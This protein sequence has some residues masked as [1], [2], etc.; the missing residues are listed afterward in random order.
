MRELGEV[1]A[2]AIRIGWGARNPAFRRLFTM[3]YLPEGTPEQ[4][5][6]FEELQ[7]T[8]ASPATAARIWAARMD[9]DVSELAP[10]VT[11][12]TLV[13]HARHA[14]TSCG[15]LGFERPRGADPNR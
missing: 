5:A 6:W 3:L 8:T 15:R 9:V 1:M 4:V 12:P 11:V 14:G 10:L 13:L 7:R 2:A